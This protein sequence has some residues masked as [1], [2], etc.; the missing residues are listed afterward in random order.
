MPKKPYLGLKTPGF[1]SFAE[2][3]RPDASGLPIAWG[4]WGEDDQLGTLNHVTAESTKA[5]AEGIRRGVRFA[6]D[7]PL[8]L[9]YAKLK[10]E[11][12]YLERGAPRHHLLGED[13]RS[14]WVRD[15]RLD[16]F[17]PQA[18][19]Q[20]DGLTHIGV[21]SL[22]FYNGVQ[23]QQLTLD[24]DTRNGIEH[25]ARLGVATRGVLLDF[26]GYFRHLDRPWDALSGERIDL[27]T[28]RACLDW[29]GVTLRRGDV[30]LCRYGWVE[31]MLAEDD[32]KTLAS[33]FQ[34]SCFSGLD[35]SSLALWEFVWNSQ[36]AALASDSPIMEAGPMEKTYNL[37]QAI[38]RLGLTLGEM[39]VLDALAADCATDGE[40]TCF[41]TSSPLH[42]RGG[43]G[44][45]PNAMA[46]K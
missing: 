32:P 29:E 46:I 17:F 18:S 34:R 27:A 12:G 19:S 3:P 33:W 8:H 13:R 25:V 21:P 24:A 30:L 9:P 15:D 7:L 43:V 45:P 40:Y 11:R 36:L 37:H 4:V 39:F 31:A 41:L 23:P 20:W 28:L 10:G 6:L 44:S 26:V 38:P 2:L 14:L 1:R 16:G 22:G 5:A 35:G 42:L